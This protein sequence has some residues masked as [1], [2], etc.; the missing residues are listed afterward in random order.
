MTKY[1]FEIWSMIQGPIIIIV[2]IGHLYIILKENSVTL[3][4]QRKESAGSTMRIN[5]LKYYEM[6]DR[7]QI[8]YVV[9]E[10]SDLFSSYGH[11]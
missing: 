8:M 7:L 9:L 10:K 4:S 1:N 3:I 5:N 2:S 6:N 11:R